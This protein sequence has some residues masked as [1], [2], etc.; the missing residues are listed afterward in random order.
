MKGLSKSTCVTT[1]LSIGHNLVSRSHYL[2]IAKVE[3]LVE[4]CELFLLLVVTSVFLGH[5]S[6]FLSAHRF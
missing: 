4:L 5:S 1:S 6:Y 2:C 3:D